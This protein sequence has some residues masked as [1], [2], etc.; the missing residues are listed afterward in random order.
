[1]TNL[2]LV[3]STVEK[4]PFGSNPRAPLTHCNC[5]IQHDDDDVNHHH[6]PTQY[7]SHGGDDNRHHDMVD[8][9]D[10]EGST[11]TLL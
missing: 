5:R 1:M 9:G 7:D 8:N 11:M 2:S 4:L 10:Y 3:G 6:C